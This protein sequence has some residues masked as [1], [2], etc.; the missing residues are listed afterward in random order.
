MGFLHGVL[1]PG[2]PIGVGSLGDEG[3]ALVRNDGQVGAVSAAEDVG[4][5]DL[6]G[7]ALGHDAAVEAD[8]PGKV[9]GDGVDL[10]GG[11]D[12]GDAL[13]VELVE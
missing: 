5:E 12:D 13:V 4:G 3:E 10:M 9:G 11:H 2:G 7:R 8:N 1:F 6:G